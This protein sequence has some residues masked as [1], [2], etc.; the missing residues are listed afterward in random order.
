MSQSEKEELIKQAAIRVFASEGFHKARMEA[1]AREA[2]V[3]VGTIYNYFTGK[4]DVLLSVFEAELEERLSFFEQLRG[5]GLTIP[6]QIAKILQEHFSLL[7]QKPELAHVLLQERFNPGEG[8]K[9]KLSNFHGRVVERIEALIKEGISQGLVRPCNPHIIAPALFAVVQSISAWEMV[10]PQSV[11]RELF[12]T[13]P[14]ELADFIWN[15]LKE[16]ESGE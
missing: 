8:F 5:S 11:V 1:I 13:A 14:A 9:D 12:Q 3:A 7:Q 15:G 2:G 4:E 16:R 10:H 6:E